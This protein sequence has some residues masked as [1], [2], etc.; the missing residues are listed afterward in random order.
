[1]EAE[2]PEGIREKPTGEAEEAA[3]EVAGVAAA[4]LREC[5]D[6]VVLALVAAGNGRELAGAESPL[7]WLA[8]ALAGAEAPGGCSSDIWA[9]ERSATGLL[10]Q[11]MHASFCLLR[12]LGCSRDAQT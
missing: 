11:W 9:L 8:A 7:F 1:M 6:V 3:V 12:R 5:S 4:G 2:K 10:G